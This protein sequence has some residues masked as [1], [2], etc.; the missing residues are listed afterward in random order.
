MAQDM[1]RLINRTARLIHL[2]NAVVGGRPLDGVK[3]SPGGNNVPRAYVEALIERSDRPAQIFQA[4]LDAREIIQDE[5]K[6]AT[7]LPEGPEPPKNLGGYKPAAALALIDAMNRVDVLAGWAKSEKRKP[8]K[9]A[10]EAKIGALG[11][12]NTEA[13]ISGSARAEIEDESDD[14]DE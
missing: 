8:I 9:A 11:G 6:N 2:P 10:L 13:G 3:L 14:T 7:K 5:R 1:I 12:S 4:M